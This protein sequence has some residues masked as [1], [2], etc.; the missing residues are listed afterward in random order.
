[1]RA[2]APAIEAPICA[3]CNRPVERFDWETSIDDDTR[4]YRA[5][6]HGETQ[7]VRLT[8]MQ[9]M[10]GNIKIDKAFDYARLPE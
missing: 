7:Q 6:C 8:S 4:T 9:M 2:I 3:V 10:K 5:Y 1:V